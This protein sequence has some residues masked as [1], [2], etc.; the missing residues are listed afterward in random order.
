MLKDPAEKKRFDLTLFFLLARGI[1]NFPFLSSNISHTFMLISNK[2]FYVF[3][4]Q[5]LFKSF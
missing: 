5:C 3:T 2:L 1:K 4:S